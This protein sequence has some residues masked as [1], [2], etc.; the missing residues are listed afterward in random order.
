MC[1]NRPT[2]HK[3]AFEKFDLAILDDVSHCS[4]NRECGEVLFNLLSGRNEKGSMA[5]A[6][7]LFFDRR[8]EVFHGLVLAG[9][10]VGCVA[11]KAHVV[12]M[13]GE[14]CGMVETTEWARKANG[15]ID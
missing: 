13:T 3:K 2:A 6:A 12:G 8:A 4:L 11:H 10:I 9:A 15:L 14:S 5:I 7:H 1:P